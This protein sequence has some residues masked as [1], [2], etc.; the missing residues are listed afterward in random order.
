MEDKVLDQILNDV[1]KAQIEELEKQLKEKDQII[2]QLR[3]RKTW[4]A[5]PFHFPEI[6]G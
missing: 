5:K 2:E 6:K 3:N 1:Y 4:I